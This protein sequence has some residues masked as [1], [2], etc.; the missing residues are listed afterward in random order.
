MLLGELPLIAQG[1]GE[2]AVEG[3]LGQAK[4]GGGLFSRMT[5]TAA[6]WAQKTTQDLRTA[7]PAAAMNRVSAAEPPAQ[8]PASPAAAQPAQPRLSGLDPADRL[9][10]RAGDDEILDIPAFLRRQAN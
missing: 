5:S 3:L 8:R 1:P 10:Q 4:R 2:G 6:S 7:T 9:A